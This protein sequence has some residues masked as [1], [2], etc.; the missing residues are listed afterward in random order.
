LYIVH[1]FLSLSYF[2]S[3]IFLGFFFFPTELIY[4]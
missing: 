4:H 2:I 3:L 1:Y